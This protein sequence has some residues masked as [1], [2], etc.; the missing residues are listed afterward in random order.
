MKGDDVGDI[1]EEHETIEVLP[2]T[3]PADPVTAPTPT[4]EPEPAPTREPEPTRDG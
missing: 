2:L 4:P 1:G 3:E